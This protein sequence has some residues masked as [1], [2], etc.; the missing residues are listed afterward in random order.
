MPLDHNAIS[1][2]YT[3]AGDR[4]VHISSFL[5]TMSECTAAVF[6]K[7]DSLRKAEPLFPATA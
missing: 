4:K 2:F 1:A 3:G 6:A 7:R 5:L